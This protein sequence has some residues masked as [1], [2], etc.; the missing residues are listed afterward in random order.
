MTTTP[1]AL[2]SNPCSTPTRPP[3]DCLNYCGDDG[4]VFNGQAQPCAAS[5]ALQTKREEASELNALAMQLAKESALESVRLVAHKV[6]SNGIVYFDITGAAGAREGAA[7]KWASTVKAAARFLV[8]AKH[9][10][11]HPTKPHMLRIL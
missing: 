3:C 10:E 4:R 8:L 11:P 5:V 6:V 9:A 2:R 1:Q 7:N